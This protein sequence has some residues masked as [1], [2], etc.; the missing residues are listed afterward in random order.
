MALPSQMAA[1]TA[2]PQPSAEPSPLPM[3]R[4]AEKPRPIETPQHSPAEEARAEPSPEPEQ[5]EDSD[6]MHELTVEEDPGLKRL[7][8]EIERLE[9]RDGELDDMLADPEISTDPEKCVQ[10]GSEK[11]ALTEK[12]TELYEKWESLSLSIIDSI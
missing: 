6:D 2:V 10:L 8:Q 7:E 1:L 12:L 4:P 5:P 9:Q 11:A 3:P